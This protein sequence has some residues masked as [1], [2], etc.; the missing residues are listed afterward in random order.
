MF[1][2]EKIDLSTSKSIKKLNYFVL[3]PTKTQR[4]SDNL[5][6]K[7]KEKYKDDNIIECI[8]CQQR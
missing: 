1:V 6:I 5:T 7:K 4:T 3:F 2:S 8:Y